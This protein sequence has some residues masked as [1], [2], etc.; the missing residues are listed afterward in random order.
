MIETRRQKAITEPIK[1][2]CKEDRVKIIEIFLKMGK[3]KKQI[4]LTI[5]TKICKTKREKEKRNI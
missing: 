1:K 4:I 5:K 3:L 2:N